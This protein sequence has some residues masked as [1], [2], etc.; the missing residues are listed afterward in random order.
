MIINNL[1]WSK[2]KEWDKTFE[3]I[4]I[5]KGWRL[6]KV[7]ELKR[8]YKTDK[9][10]KFDKEYK[11][12]WHLFFC[13]QTKFAKEN[14]YFSRV[15]LLSDGDLGASVG[16]LSDSGGDGRVVFCRELKQKLTGN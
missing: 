5:P 7:T 3:E 4:E 8:I 16:V 2:I 14:N 1:E 10:E 6:P 11:K 9:A 13:Q 15:Y 12:N